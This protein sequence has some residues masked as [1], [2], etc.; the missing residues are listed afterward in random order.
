MGTDHAAGD[1]SE[2]GAAFW[3]GFGSGE[4][5]DPVFGALAFWVDLVDFDVAALMFVSCAG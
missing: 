5:F 3:L 4:G 2:E 1:G